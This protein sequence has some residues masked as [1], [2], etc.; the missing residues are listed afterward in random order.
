M[1][2]GG[3]GGGVRGLGLCGKTRPLG[4]VLEVRHRGAAQPSVCSNNRMATKGLANRQER[5]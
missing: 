2:V 5:F 4:K 3:G 1:G